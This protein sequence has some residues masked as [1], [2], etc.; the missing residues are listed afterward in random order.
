MYKY[1][2]NVD[3]IIIFWNVAPWLLV[4]ACQH[5]G[6]LASFIVRIQEALSVDSHNIFDSVIGIA[7]GYGLDNRGVGV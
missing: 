1:L 5:F 3:R 6:E 7:T 2:L 4:D